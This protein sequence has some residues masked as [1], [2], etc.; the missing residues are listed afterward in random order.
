MA[1]TIPR[2]AIAQPLLAAISDP[3]T[4]NNLPPNGTAAATYAQGAG[5]ARNLTTAETEG[6]H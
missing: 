1:V 4:R 3:P 5:L 2:R 6:F